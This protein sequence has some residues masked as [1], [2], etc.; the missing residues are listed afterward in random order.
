MSLEAIDS[1]FMGT[2][3]PPEMTEVGLQ[4]PS[5]VPG[6]TIHTKEQCEVIFNIARPM[7]DAPRRRKMLLFVGTALLAGGQIE[8]G[9]ETRPCRGDMP[10]EL[11]ASNVTVYAVDRS[12]G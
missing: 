5:P 3:T 12:D 9:G 1:P 8:S 6:A 4:S 10:R 11:A 7:R 2:N